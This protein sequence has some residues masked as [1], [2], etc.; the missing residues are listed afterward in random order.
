MKT[1]SRVPR[2]TDLCIKQAK[3]RLLTTELLLCLP[4]EVLG[5]LCGTPA[6]QHGSCIVLI[7]D[8]PLLVDANMVSGAIC[9]FH[10]FKR[11]FVFGEYQ[12]NVFQDSLESARWESSV[13]LKDIVSVIGDFCK[14][15]P[16]DLNRTNYNPNPK[17]STVQNRQGI[18][19][20]LYQQITRW[21]LKHNCNFSLKISDEFLKLAQKE[22]MKVR[23]AIH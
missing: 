21:V 15:A 18:E 12:T 11:E 13:P 19:A 17:H 1:V 10:L 5:E 20:L 14:T 4:Q 2:L 3:T 23:M 22:T 8:T 6:S 16:D 7:N 9:G